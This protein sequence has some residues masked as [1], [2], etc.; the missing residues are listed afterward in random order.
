M[1]AQQIDRTAEAAD[2]ASERARK[3]EKVDFKMISFSLAGKEY[4]IDIMSVKEIAKAGRF[5]YVPNAAPFVRGVYNLRGEIIPVIDMRIFFHLPAERKQEDALES[6]IIVRVGDHV[7]GIIVDAIDKVVGISSSSIQPPHPIFGDINVKYIKGITES[8]GKL[9]IILDVERIFSP[10]RAGEDS[11][12]GYAR[13]SSRGEDKAEPVAVTPSKASAGDISA[14]FV[15][16]TLAAFKSFHVTPI[17]ERWFS[18]RFSEWKALRKGEEL[19]LREAAEADEFLEGFL[20]PCSGRLWDEDY[21]AAVGAALPGIESKNINVWNPGCGKGYETWSFACVMKMKYPEARIKIWAN[22]SDLLAISMAPNMAFEG[23]VPE[24][25]LPFMSK[26]RSGLVFTQA[27]RDSIFFEFHDVLNANT[28]PSI[29]LVLCR[30]ML[31]FV[32]SIDQRRL[33]S[34]FS[35]KLKPGGVVLCGANEELGE[36]WAAVGSGAVKAFRK[37]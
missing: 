31:S 34:D 35:E 5:T 27:I 13:A 33:L 23:A 24:Y 12:E 2:A 11:A 10:E 6:L 36:G 21:A 22:D 15:R 1:T 7:F 4:G 28:L 26:G 25:C 19:Q 14:S 29:D 30:D 17:N 16:E 32:S 20:S 8:V 18:S 37:E 9:Y 3:A